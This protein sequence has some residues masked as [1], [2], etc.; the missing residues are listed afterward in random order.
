M[1]NDVHVFVCNL[2]FSNCRYTP[3]EGHTGVSTVP[4]SCG[5]SL[6][7]VCVVQVTKHTSSKFHVIDYMQNVALVLDYT[8]SVR[9]GGRLVTHV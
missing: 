5:A 1:L 3:S 4:T 8:S 2:V 9:S 6:H 7:R